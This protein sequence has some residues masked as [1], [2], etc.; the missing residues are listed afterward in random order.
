M[1]RY[2]WLSIQLFIHLRREQIIFFLTKE[3]EL[4]LGQQ[5]IYVNS[6]SIFQFSHLFLMYSE[7]YMEFDRVQ[8]EQLY[9]S[10]LAVSAGDGECK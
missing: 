6:E 2:F 5:F 10:K 1:G 3:V 7:L 9:C 4:R 8:L